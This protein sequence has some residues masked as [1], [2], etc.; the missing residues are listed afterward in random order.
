MTKEQNNNAL[1]WNMTNE[2]KQA[3]QCRKVYIDQA[4][5]AVP[6]LLNGA[7]LFKQ[8]KVAIVSRS[9]PAKPPDRATDAV[10]FLTSQRTRLN[11]TY[12]NNR[13]VKTINEAEKIKHRR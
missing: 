10:K 4:R 5:F 1:L 3:C 7:E 13:D 9:V 12:D 2:S 6:E 11:V 8:L